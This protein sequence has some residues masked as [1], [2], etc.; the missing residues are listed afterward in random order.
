MNRHRRRWVSNVKYVDISL[1]VGVV[2]MGIITKADHVDLSA[3]IAICQPRVRPEPE[4][5]NNT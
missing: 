2:V 3:S 1:Y 4:R 5:K